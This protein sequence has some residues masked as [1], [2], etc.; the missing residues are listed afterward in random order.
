VDKPT[1][2]LTPYLW[3]VISELQ[4]GKRGE[5]EEKKRRKKEEKKEEEN[6]KSKI[7]KNVT[8]IH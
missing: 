2:A 5:K 6:A 4:K 3:R 1:R 7:A 8:L